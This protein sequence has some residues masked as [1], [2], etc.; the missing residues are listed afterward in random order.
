MA[1]VG[2]PPRS[3]AS[4]ALGVGWVSSTR[5]GFLL[6]IKSKVQ[7]ESS[8]P[9]PHPWPWTPKWEPMTSELWESLTWDSGREPVRLFIHLFVFEPLVFVAR[10]CISLSVPSFF[11]FLYSGIFLSSILSFLLRTQSI[12]SGISSYSLSTTGGALTINGD[13]EASKALLA[14]SKS[15]A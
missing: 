5:R 15:I 3:T 10:R 7:L 2:S 1:V 11:S 12:I 4:L 8:W 9:R 6:L 13:T 14:L